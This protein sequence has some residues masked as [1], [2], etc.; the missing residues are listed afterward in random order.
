M[1]PRAQKA[2]TSS[3]VV[4]GYKMYIDL[5]RPLLSG[6]EVIAT[7]MMGELQ[8]CQ[9]A[10]D[11]ALAG[12]RV[13]LISSGDVGVYGM[14]GLALEICQERGLRL[15]PLSGGPDVDLPL[16]VVPGVPALAAAAAL[17]G[18]PLMHDFA[19]VS[20]S[21][22]MTPWEVIK[23]RVDAAAAADFVLVIYNPKSKKRDWQLAE[24]REI[25]LHHRQPETPVGIVSRAM[26]AGQEV[27]VTN[28]GEMLKHPVDM[29]TIIIIGNSQTYQAGGH[30]ITPRGYL[31]K[32]T[33]GDE[34]AEA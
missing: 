15:G 31:A 21:D 1:T 4:V 33:L 20:L 5:V 30:M 2:L 7:G 16:E 8:R 13:A 3:Q 14:A 26:R 9:L 22:L 12:S 28:L 18:A 25:L 24:V 32:Y 23:K 10:I 27:T 34:K 17:L 6:Q 11:R 19:S 29:Q